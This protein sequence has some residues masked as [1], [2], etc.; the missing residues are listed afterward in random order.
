MRKRFR[1]KKETELLLRSVVY[2]RLKYWLLQTFLC[3]WSAKIYHLLA[4][5]VPQ[6]RGLGLMKAVQ[7]TFSSSE[8]Q[9]WYTQ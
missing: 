9:L 1:S 6:Q 4:I 7:Y 5:Y 2:Y 3:F 8:M